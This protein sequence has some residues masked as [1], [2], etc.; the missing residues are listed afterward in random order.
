MGLQAHQVRLP[1]TLL[2]QSRTPPSVKGEGQ[3]PATASQESVVQL[4][5]QQQSSVMAKPLPTRVATMQIPFA[6]P[7]QPLKAPPGLTLP[8]S[9]VRNVS[10]PN[11][12]SPATSVAA[13]LTAVSRGNEA[14]SCASSG[15]QAS[16]VSASSD[17]VRL[18]QKGGAAVSGEG[19]PLPSRPH[20][21][22][23]VHKT[24]SQQEETLPGVQPSGRSKDGGDGESSPSKSPG[25]TTENVVDVGTPRQ[26]SH[27]MIAGGG[28][29]GGGSGDSP[30]HSGGSLESSP[31]AG[32]VSSGNG[33]SPGS[34]GSAAR[35]VSSAGGS[36]EGGARSAPK[37][38]ETIG[39]NAQSGSEPGRGPEDGAVS[40]TPGQ[41]S[42]APS[43]DEKGPVV[44]CEEDP[45]PK[46][47][48]A[49]VVDQIVRK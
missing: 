46:Q 5:L 6:Q 8:T 15:V 27:V 11:S 18:D 3:M 29:R 49:K 37:V 26:S 17:G 23:P 30:S 48:R 42:N 40:S 1:Q 44:N 10:V 9:V 19:D 34:C 41:L 21:F 28:G 33:T 38:R 2:S 25:R 20:P 39:T 22:A 13:S 45:L 43:R 12:A 31:G 35:S 14:P 24:T 36:L 47:D 16:L 4:M 7:V 32:S